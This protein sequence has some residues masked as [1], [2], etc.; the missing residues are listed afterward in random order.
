MNSNTKNIVRY[1]MSK[2][3]AIIVVV[4]FFHCWVGLAGAHMIL[5]KD[6]RHVHVDGSA[7]GDSFNV[8]KSPKTP[9]SN[10]GE[11]AFG[12]NFSV[13]ASSEAIAGQHSIISENHFYASGMG[14]GYA[15]SRN[16]NG[17]ARY[18][19]ESLFEVV[20]EIEVPH[21]YTLA[22]DSLY[23]WEEGSARISLFKE[24]LAVFEYWSVSDISS[25]VFHGHLDSGIYTFIAAADFRGS[26]RGDQSSM[27][28]EAKY[29]LDFSVH[30]VVPEPATGSIFFFLFGLMGIAKF[31]KK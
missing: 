18:L 4:L 28:G 10:F 27:Y 5:M 30:S 29:T 12:K 16:S 9:F 20:F 17:Y 11:G 26:A 19:C 22:I 31:A 24:D 13:N 14:H 2:C 15:S 25:A 21:D 8:S 7:G 1:I 23:H 3:F 6:N